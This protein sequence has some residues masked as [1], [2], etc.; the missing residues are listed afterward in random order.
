MLFLVQR[1]PLWLTEALSRFKL[2]DGYI[3]IDT[4]LVGSGVLI[5]CVCVPFKQHVHALKKRS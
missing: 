5:I 3:T 4:P 2:V 1:E